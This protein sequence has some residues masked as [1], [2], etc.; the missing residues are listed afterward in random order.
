MGRVRLSSVKRSRAD[1]VSAPK[2]AS[3]GKWAA[4]SD[5]NKAR[6]AKRQRKHSASA[7]RKRPRPL[8][9]PSLS[10][11]AVKVSDKTPHS[12]RPLKRAKRA[13]TS[14]LH[15]GLGSD[16]RDANVRTLSS[17]HGT[18]VI[19]L[20]KTCQVISKA[21]RADWDNQAVSTIWKAACFDFRS[22]S[23]PL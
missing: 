4:S 22:A 3:S 2:R 7:A 17:R 19:C 9:T 15:S 1:R 12:S 16:L 8:P 23:N 5:S 11:G 21:R 18:I 14:S 6:S 13:S 20:G 10:A